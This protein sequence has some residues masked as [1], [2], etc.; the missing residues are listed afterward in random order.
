MKKNS[1]SNSGFTLIELIIAMAM[2]AFVM[3]AV[4]SF[5]GSGVLGYKK[6]KADITVHNS[7]QETY[8]NL[9]DTAMQANDIIIYGYTTKDADDEIVFGLEGEDVNVELNS[10]KAYYVRDDAQAEYIKSS[11]EYDGTDNFVLYSSLPAGTKIYA[12]KIIVESAV[13][14]DPAYATEAEAD[15]YKNAFLSE[16]AGADV[17]IE[18]KQEVRV[19]SDGS[20]SDVTSSIGEN[21]YTENDTMRTVF[22]FDAEKLYYETK[23]AYMTALNDYYTGTGDSL[24]DYLYSESFNY[25]TIKD[26][27]G[28][29]TGTVTGCIVTVNPADGT[30][31]FD[32]KFS[33]KNMTYNS[34]GMVLF[35]NSYVLRAKQ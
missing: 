10:T 30:F 29:E 3:T 23:Y 20:T 4:S 28:A 6:A 33:D 5:M 34:Q 27:T 32:L 1:K 15:K 25:S 22:T 7:A 26:E 12:E 11:A 9:V 19:N 2:L 21:V 18:I 16:A 35:R 8:N 13:P 31:S 14:F 24:E 17:T